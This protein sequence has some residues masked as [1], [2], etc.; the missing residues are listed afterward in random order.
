MNEKGRNSFWGFRP[1]SPARSAK[2]NSDDVYEKDAAHSVGVAAGRLRPGVRRCDRHPSGGPKRLQD[3]VGRSQ[4]NVALGDAMAGNYCKSIGQ[5]FPNVTLNYGSGEVRFQCFKNGDH[6]VP[7]YPRAAIGT[8]STSAMKP[9]SVL[10]ATALLIALPSAHAARS[11]RRVVHSGHRWSGRRPSDAGQGA[12]RRIAPATPPSTPRRGRS[13]D[14]DWVDLHRDHGTRL[15]Q[16]ATS[17]LHRLA[18]PSRAA[19][20]LGN[21]EA[22]TGVFTFVKF[23]AETS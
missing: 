7:A 1:P 16:G 14:D 10:A 11:R 9:A 12:N 19:K 18:Q 5:D 21:L 6:L 23:R 2:R 8:P 13:A 17:P 3:R 20:A 4:E 22:S 15:A